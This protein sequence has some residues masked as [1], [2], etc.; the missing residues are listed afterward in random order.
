MDFLIARMPIYCERLGSSFFGEPLNLFTNLFYVGYALLAQRVLNKAPVAHR[1]LLRFLVVMVAIIGIGSAAFHAVPNPFTLLADVVPIYAFLLPALVLLLKRLTNTWSYAISLAVA[2]ACLL[3][4]A[5]VYVPPYF[6]NGSIRHVIMFVGLTGLVYWCSQK[7][8]RLALQL[9][10][11][12]G[13]YALAI[14]ARSV[15]RQVCSAMPI[16]THFLWHTLNS[17]ALLLFIAFLIRL[18]TQS[19]AKTYDVLLSARA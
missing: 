15:D 7:Y 5:S 14:T 6:L 2:F 4:L 10:P 8:G 19:P 1:G 13:L 9:V 12:L 18:D 16:G 3:V 17:L 11:V